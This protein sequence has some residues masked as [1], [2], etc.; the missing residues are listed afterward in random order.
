MHHDN[1]FG[2]QNSL[3]ETTESVMTTMH[4][5]EGCYGARTQWTTWREVHLLRGRSTSSWRQ[6]QLCFLTRVQENSETTIQSHSNVKHP[7]TTLNRK[8]STFSLSSTRTE[9]PQRT[10]RQLHVEDIRC[11]LLART[12]GCREMNFQCYIAA[13]VPARAAYS[14]FC[15][16]SINTFAVRSQHKQHVHISVRTQTP[17]TRNSVRSL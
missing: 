1:R 3:D 13:P 16:R 6:V 7:E 15:T 5:N 2:L 10:C 8:T 9:L 11:S 12:F 4:P 14:Q 17:R